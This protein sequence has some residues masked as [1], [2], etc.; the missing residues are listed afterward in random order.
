MIAKYFFNFICGCF[1]FRQYRLGQLGMKWGQIE[2][3][4][5][6]EKFKIDKKKEEKIYERPSL[7][8]A[9]IKGEYGLNDYLEKNFNLQMFNKVDAVTNKVDIFIYY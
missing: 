3:F 1:L 9:N 2:Q 6:I 8:T 5:A 7:F 4:L